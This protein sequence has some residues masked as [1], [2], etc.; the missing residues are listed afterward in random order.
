MPS[1]DAGFVAADS[2]IVGNACLYGATGGDFH[3]N[4][5]AGERFGVRNSGAFAVAEGAGDHCCEYMT[6]GVVVIL[7]SVGRNVG[8]GMTGGLG[9]FY[10]KA[11][12]F[13]KK[14]NTEI[15]KMQRL[16][17][18]EAEAQLRSMIERHYELTGSERADEIL[19]NWDTEKANFWQVYP[20]SES[21]TA[22]VQPA[23][24]IV[25]DLRV[26]ASAPDG[27]MCFLPVGAQMSPEQTQRCAD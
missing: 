15:V 3:A 18:P 7:G 8:A 24:D 6:G 22:L 4:G 17:T 14:L 9:Y 19:S 25:A 5:R 11:G 2:S 10:D 23:S 27:E 26:S 20:P 13:E 21:K 16:S 1:G 12:D